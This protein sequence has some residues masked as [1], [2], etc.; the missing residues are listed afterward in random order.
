MVRHSTDARTPLDVVVFDLDETLYPRDSGIMQAIGKRITLYIEQIFNL[1]TNRAMTLRSE[2]FQRHGTTLRGLQVNH[3][4]DADVYMEFVHDV[5]VEESVG[6]DLRLD[7][8]LEQIDAEKVV[9]TNASREHA[10]RVLNA[11]GIRHHFSRIIDVR[12]ME[13]VSKPAP[14]AYSRLLELLGTPGERTMLVEDNVRNLRPAAELGIVTVLVDGNGE[15]V[16][17]FVI[18]EIWQIGE[19]YASLDGGAAD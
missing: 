6:Y 17:D 7:Q 2:Y 1:P 14:S 8:A 16:A 9:F 10:E 3:D 4:V 11:R 18:D 12:D 15:G 19:V 5:P 13:W